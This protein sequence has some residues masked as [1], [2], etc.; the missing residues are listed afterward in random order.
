MSEEEI[1][2]PIRDFEQY[3]VSNLG[4]VLRKD[5]TGPRKIALNHKGFPSVT[6]YA[7][8]STSRYLRQVNKLVAEA[9][10][11]A[12]RFSDMTAVWHIDGDLLNCRADNLLW[13]TRARV[14]EW[15]EMHRRGRPSLV[16]PKVKN[17]RTGITYDNAYTCGMAESQL[18]SSIVWRVERQGRHPE[19]DAARYRYVFEDSEVSRRRSADGP[20]F[21]DPISGPAP[22]S[23][24]D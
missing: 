5:G 1:W 3:Q 10:L 11:P 19:D 16:T 18:E 9:H 7:E 23:S 24:T 15:N 22:D 2:L 21:R 20:S 8:D 6:L 17:N 4:R 14:L 12:P 13:D